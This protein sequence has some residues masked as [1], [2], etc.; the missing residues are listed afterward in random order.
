MKIGIITWHNMQ[1]YGS[2]LQAYAL[3]KVLE[4]RGHIVK[5]IDYRNFVPSRLKARIFNSS[6]LTKKIKILATKGKWKHFLKF[7]NKYLKLTRLILTNDE[8]EKIGQ[9]F[10]CYICGSDQIWSPNVFDKTYFLDFVPNEK[11]KI[12]YSTSVVIDGYNNEQKEIISKELKHFRAISLRENKGAQIIKNITGIDCKVNLDPTLLLEKS[13]WDKLTKDTKTE[14]SYLLCYMLNYNKEQIE[15]VRQ[16]AE[17]NN[18]KIINIGEDDVGIGEWDINVGPLEFLNYVKNAS[19]VCTDSYHGSLF[20]INFNKQF[21]TFERF[22]GNDT[23]N[24][25]DRIYE[26]LEKLNL[27][28]RIVTNSDYSKQVIDFTSVNN[29]LKKYRKES[30]QYINDNIE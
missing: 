22:K 26:I 13:D 6:K 29:K 28:Y 7:Q 4:Q 24:Q 2:M 12:S 5:V 10:D 17:T 21:Y 3:Q 16:I 23:I 11:I 18:L 30:L 15:I 9:Q 27:S 25:N 19:I 8:L 20:S 1:N 14:E